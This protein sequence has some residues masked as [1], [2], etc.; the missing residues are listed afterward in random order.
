MKRLIKFFSFLIF[1]L[2]IAIVAAPFLIPVETVKKIATD[3]VRE[4]TGRELVI[5]GDIKASI[6]PTIGINLQNVALS[7]PE[8]FADKNM[9]EIGEVNV[10]VALMPLLSG[11]VEVEQFSVHKPIIHLEVNKKGISNWQFAKEEGSDKTAVPET[12]PTAPKKSAMA[13]PVLGKVRVDGGDFTYK[14]MRSG[15]I[16]TAKD[17]ALDIKMPSVDAPL[18]VVAALTLNNE[19]INFSTNIAQPGQLAGGGDSMVKATA[20]I[21]SLL[22]MNFDG[23]A[24]MKNASGDVDLNIPSLISMSGFMGKKMEW[25]GDTP[26]ALAIAGQLACNTSECDFSKAKLTLDD[27]ILTGAVKAKLEGPAPSIEAKLS[28]DKFNLNHYFPKTEKQASLPFINDAEAASGWDSKPIDLSALKTVNAKMALDIGELLYQNTTLSKVGLTLN[29]SGGVLNLDIPHA[30]LYE[31]T[32]KLSTTLNSTGALAAKV[33][34]DKVQIEPLLKDFANF[35]RLTG[36][37]ALDVSITGKMTSQRDLMSSLNGEGKMAVNDGTIRGVDIAKVVNSAKALVTG[38]DTS[39][40]KTKFSE[41]GGTFTIKQGI[42]TNN[43]FAMKAP[44]LRVTGSGIVDL[45][46]RYVKYRLLPSVVATLQGQGG[47]D[48]TGL[49]IPVNV[50]GS[51]DSLKF[52]PDLAGAAQNVLKDP[53][54]VKDTVKSVK[55]SIKQSGGV[56]NLLK[57]FR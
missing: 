46:N 2:I 39:S 22:T 51:F 28:A 23:K 8:G 1:L 48:K 41:L 7:N 16:Y 10:G 56:K 57:G 38:V 21:G 44:L 14:D 18:D 15:K 34:I 40:E 20:K 36:V 25:K 29:L 33:N 11:K 52:T 49:E 19:K 12:T 42:V 31:G 50:E 6:F 9:A 32:A 54:K 27:S 13:L 47:K 35:D 17:V 24:S 45:P 5:G 4:M 55:D 3:K 43:D 37:S 26:V 53:Q 30:G